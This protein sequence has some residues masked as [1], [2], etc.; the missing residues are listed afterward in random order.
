MTEIRH[1]VVIKTA[2]ENVYKAITTQEGL[3]NWWA[4]QTTAKPQVGF[5]NTFIFGE[6]R[7]EMKVTVLNPNKKVEWHCIDSIEEWIDTNI[8][9][10]LE[11]KDGRTILRFTHAGWQAVTDTFADC[12][13]N[14]AKFMFSLK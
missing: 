5:I 6:S 10:D 13:Y 12:N 3:A 14:W 2:P 7:N 8:S 1:N 4:K 11:E 9:F